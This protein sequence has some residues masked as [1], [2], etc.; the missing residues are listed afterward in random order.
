MSLGDAGHTPHL[1]IGGCRS[2]KSRHGESLITARRPPYFYVATAQ[3]YDN[4]MRERVRRHQARRSSDWET[5]E[6]PYELSRCLGDLA[7]SERPVLVDCLTLWITNLL[8]KE[9]VAYTER[10]VEQLCRILGQVRYPLVLVSNEVGAGIVPDN[11][12]AR[13]FR[14]LMG[15]SNQQ[16]AAACASVTWMIAGI[17][18]AIKGNGI[19]P[20]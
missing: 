13:T 11:T 18:V 16:I 20:R 10:A 12:L 9:D 3:V 1:V 15:W 5:I 8:L 14:D 17:P 2:G 4:E 19:D 6:C 7:S